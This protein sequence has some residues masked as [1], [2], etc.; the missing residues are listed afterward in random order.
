[1]AQKIGTNW[2]Q[3]IPDAGRRLLRNTF[4][5]ICLELRYLRRESVKALR[6]AFDILIP[7]WTLGV[8][9]QG[10]ADSFFKLGGQC[11]LKTDQWNACFTMLQTCLQHISS[12]RVDHHGVLPMH[13][14]DGGDT[15]GMIT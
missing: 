4:C 10:L 3:K 13:V 5:N 12:M 14:T 6:Q 15:M 8:Q 2:A 11:S 9:S 1:M 7:R